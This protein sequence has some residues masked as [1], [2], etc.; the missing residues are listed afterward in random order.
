MFFFPW[1]NLHIKWLTWVRT[2]FIVNKRFIF[3]E[4]NV[5]GY[6]FLTG[7]CLWLIP[8]YQFEKWLVVEQKKGGFES[9]LFHG[10]SRYKQWQPELHFPTNT[11]S[12]A[13]SHKTNIHFCFSLSLSIYIYIVVCVCVCYI[14]LCSQNN[15]CSID[16]CVLAIAGRLIGRRNTKGNT[17]NVR[18]S[19]AS[20]PVSGTVEVFENR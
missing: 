15:C 3:P 16:D 17:S 8:R 4:C 12:M 13:N 5:D 10:R 19:V 14:K 6:L 11:I 18:T 9:Y 20:F 7:S 2:F 1:R